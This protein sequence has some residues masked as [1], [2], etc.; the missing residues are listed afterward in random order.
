MV[1][2]AVWIWS[3]GLAVLAA[4]GLAGWQTIRAGR[5]SRDLQAAQDSL[6]GCSRNRDAARADA[7]SLS[8]RLAALA[9]DQASLRAEAVALRRAEAEART[10]LDAAPFPIWRRDRDGRLVWVNARYAHLAEASAADTVKRGLELASSH[11]LEQPRDLALAALQAGSLQIQDRRFVA[12]GDRRN[13]RVYE[14]PVGEGTLGSGRTSPPRPMPVASCAAIW[15][16]IWKC[17]VPSRPLPP[18]TGR[19]ASC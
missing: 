1:I 3:L 6:D 10:L 18:S 8:D 12:E 13:Y 2:G 19:T 9:A 16:R 17:C 14:Q 5:L 11:D 15:T 7:A 4:T